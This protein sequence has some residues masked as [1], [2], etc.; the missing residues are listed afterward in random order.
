MLCLHYVDLTA[1]KRFYLENFLFA[2]RRKSYVLRAATSN[3]MLV[4][5]LIIIS[6]TSW[7]KHWTVTQLSFGSFLYTKMWLYILDCSFG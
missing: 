4:L 1:L 5:H 7:S 2:H 6:Q 3:K